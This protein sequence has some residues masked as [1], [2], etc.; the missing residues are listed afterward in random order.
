MGRFNRMAAVP[1]EHL[2][3][4]GCAALQHAV[5]GAGIPRSGFD[6]LVDLGENIAVHV[7][8]AVHVRQYGQ[9]STI[10]MPARCG[11]GNTVL[12]SNTLP[13]IEGRPVLLVW[14]P[15]VTNVAWLPLVKASILAR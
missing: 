13:G 15:L 10:R 8:L 11:S 1:G 12:A 5:H 6:E 9:C 7:D 2:G 4:Q 3:G 14:P